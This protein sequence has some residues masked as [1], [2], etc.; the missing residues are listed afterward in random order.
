MFENNFPLYQK[1]FYAYIES[2]S[3]A[4]NKWKARL[5]SPNI[6]SGQGKCFSFSYHMFGQTTGKNILM[7]YSVP[8]RNHIMLFHLILLR[9]FTPDIA[10]HTFFEYLDKS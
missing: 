5:V 7:L 10:G 3:P 6:E 2:S 8:K 4:K 9:N 1:G